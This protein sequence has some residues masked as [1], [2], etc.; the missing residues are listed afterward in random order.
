[1]GGQPLRDCLGLMDLIVIDGH[2]NPG[3]P[4]GEVLDL[5]APE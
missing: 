2:V 5:Q 3:V 4:V 1:V